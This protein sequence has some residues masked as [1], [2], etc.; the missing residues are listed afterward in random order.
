MMELVTA[1]MPVSGTRVLGEKLKGRCRS[2]ESRPDRQVPCRENRDGS[3]GNALF[4]E[5]PAER[6]EGQDG[7]CG[8]RQHHGQ[9]HGPPHDEE[10][11]CV[12][13]SVRVSPGHQHVAALHGGRETQHND[14]EQSG[15]HD[16]ALIP[17]CKFNHQASADEGLPAS[18]N[19]TAACNMEVREV[20]MATIWS[21]RRSIPSTL[22]C[23]WRTRL[24]RTQTLDASDTLA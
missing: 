5:P 20:G 3:S 24:P 15:E 1:I 7:W 9:H 10:H 12:G 6:A 23:H 16:P 18:V 22:W 19:D 17:G 13:R 8:G 2:A 11:E 21:R 4:R 14:Q